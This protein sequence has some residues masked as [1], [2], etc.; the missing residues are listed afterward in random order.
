MV[1]IGLA[2]H[3]PGTPTTHY[4]RMGCWPCGLVDVPT[5]WWRCRASP[6]IPLASRGTSPPKGFGLVNVLPRSLGGLLWLTRWP[7]RPY[8]ATTPYPPLPFGERQHRTSSWLLGL[9]LPIGLRPGL[10][11]HLPARPALVA[12]NSC[13]APADRLL[14]V[15]NES[16]AWHMGSQ[17][18]PPMRGG[19]TREVTP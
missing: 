5:Q 18:A 10:S 12:P 7:S 9:P 2:S 6:F 1:L 14:G 3:L 17:R 15:A 19:P 4:G 8:R 16:T 11:G 13:N